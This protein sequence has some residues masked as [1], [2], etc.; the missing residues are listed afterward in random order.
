M[1]NRGITLAQYKNAAAIL[2][3]EV[4]AIQAVDD[5]E[6]AGN[7]FLKNGKLKILFEGHKFFIHTQGKFTTSN[8][9]LCYKKYTDKFYNLNQWERFEAASKLDPIAA[10]L[11]CSWG[12]FQIMGDEY[13][14]CGYISVLEM[15]KDF[16]SSEGRHL[17]AVCRFI[18]SKKIDDD[19][20]QLN[21]PT[22]AYYYNGKNYKVNDYDVKLQQAY[23]KF[24]KLSL[25]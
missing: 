21:W 22:F 24:K 12:R 8:P 20:R 18:I 10:A 13:K 17:I 7:G 25:L 23:L 19:L 1:E 14:R 3:C 16:Q 5:V 6:S 4:A 9:D 15:V 2:K 11:S